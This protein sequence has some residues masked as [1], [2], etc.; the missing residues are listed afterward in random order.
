MGE[1]ISQAELLGGTGNCLVT[2]LYNCHKNVCL[3][4]LGGMTH[5]RKLERLELDNLKS[6]PIFDGRLFKGSQALKLLI[7]ARHVSD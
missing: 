5:T 7:R 6:A 2:H 4:H 1:K 3:K